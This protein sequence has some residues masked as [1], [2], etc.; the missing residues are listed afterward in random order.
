MFFIILQNWVYGKGAVDK[1]WWFLQLN[2][3][4]VLQIIETE[5]YEET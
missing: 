5:H 1:L 3:M 4:K 2:S